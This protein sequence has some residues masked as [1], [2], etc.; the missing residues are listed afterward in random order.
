MPALPSP[1]QVIKIEFIISDDSSI[2]AT[3]RFF[4][5]Y[6]GTTPDASSLNSL[7]SG[8]KTQWA[9]N[10]AAI[11][12]S[13]ENLVEVICTDL[14]SADGA[15]GQW[16]GSQAGALEGD[17]LESPTCAQVLH[18]VNRR[19]RGGRPRTYLRCGAQSVLL[20][21]NMWTT[22]FQ[23]EVLSSWQAWI[24]GVLGLTGFIFTLDN[25][26]NVSWYSGFTAFMEPSGR[27]RNIPK[28]RDTPI[29]DSIVNSVVPQLISSQR[30]RKDL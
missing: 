4:V 1:G 26:V 21:S 10:M 22:D 2:N 25:I 12:N 28:L 6:T 18:E 27:Y 24:T 20:T 19:Y 11:T 15:Q 17:R 13:V 7:A 30:R 29:V 8:V 23:T 5:T 3:S 16:T 14:S 9:D